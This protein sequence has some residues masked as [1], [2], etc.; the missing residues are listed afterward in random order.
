MKIIPAID[1]LN[2]QIVRLTEG[3]YNQK[4][5]YNNH[6]EL[7]SPLVGMM[8]EYY[9]RD[10][11][12]I[13]VIDL[14]GAKN[15]SANEVFIFDAIKKGKVKIQVGG[16]IRS[17][18]K[19]EK[20]LDAGVYRVILGTV[21]I[22]NPEF[23]E[24]AIKKFDAE[25]MIIAIDVLHE[26]I[27]YN[28]W[29]ESSPVKLDDFIGKCMALGFE[30]FL[31]TDI[32]KDGKLEGPSLPL[33][34]KLIKNFPTMKLIASGGVSSMEDIKELSATGAESVVVGKAIFENKI[35]LDAIS[36]WNKVLFS[37]RT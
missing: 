29:L 28:G 13:H 35:S 2:C 30:R 11:D 25:K 16:G 32:S 34:D 26:V 22:T 5:I 36:N 7:A 18:D 24:Q 23:L 10:M 19:I 1:I 17:I 27:K 14:N 3:D 37:G 21:A 15:D 31:C 20:M 4:T 33:Y 12:H 9:E 6:S 8:Q